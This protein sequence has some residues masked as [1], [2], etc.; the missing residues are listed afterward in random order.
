MNFEGIYKW[1]PLREL[2]KRNQNVTFRAVITFWGSWGSDVSRVFFWIPLV[3]K[4]IHCSVTQSP[5]SPWEAK[6]K[7]RIQYFHIAGK[8]TLVGGWSSPCPPRW[9]TFEWSKNKLFRFFIS[10][11]VEFPTKW[12][13]TLYKKVHSSVS[14]SSIS[15]STYFF[16][17]VGSENRVF[18]K[19]LCTQIY[20][21]IMEM[22]TLLFLITH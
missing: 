7:N 5:L 8:G 19:S 2:A 6:K 10:N 18:Q 14:S 4:I 21:L 3:S 16:V 20:V 13:V 22:F 11:R 12:W 15:K 1:E 9:W 17:N